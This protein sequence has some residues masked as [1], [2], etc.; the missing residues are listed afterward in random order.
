MGKRNFAESEFIQGFL[1][2]YAAN[3]GS[4]TADEMLER[5][6]GTNG[7]AIGQ[8]FTLTG[9]I[10]V[11]ERKIN[12]TLNTYLVLPTVEGIDLSLMSLMSVTSLKGY[13]LTNECTIEYDV[14]EGNKSVKKSRT[15]KTELVEDFDFSMVWKP[16]TRV[17]LQLADMIH[18]GEVD[19]KGKTVTYLGTA[20][21]PIKSKKAGESNGEKFGVDYWRA[22][23]SKLW[24]IE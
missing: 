17:F 5:T 15:T 4:K 8:T 9:D 16:A 7:Y 3:G 11:R 1:A 13:D 12:G 18:E 19:L 22:I 2:T 23:E 6:V 14:K 10:V 24:S 21:K 20:V